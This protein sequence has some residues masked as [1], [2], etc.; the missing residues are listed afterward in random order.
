MF[1]CY[2]VY[3]SVM[4]NLCYR[5]NTMKA[6]FKTTLNCNIVKCLNNIFHHKYL[7]K[8]LEMTVQESIRSYKSIQNARLLKPKPFFP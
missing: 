3:I 2:N 6:L 1:C 4:N 5:H 8:F 7:T